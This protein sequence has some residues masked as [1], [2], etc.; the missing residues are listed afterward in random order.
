MDYG[1]Q[2]LEDV[3]QV[4]IESEK[5]ADRRIAKIVERE[6]TPP[7]IIEPEAVEIRCGHAVLVRLPVSALRV[8]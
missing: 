3:Q 7:P 4:E 2:I 1:E 5:L 8:H 6:P